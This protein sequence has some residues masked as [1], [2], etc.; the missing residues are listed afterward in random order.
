MQFILTQH[1]FETDASFESSVMLRPVSEELRWKFV[2]AGS[3]DY[4]RY[5]LSL[6]GQV[7]SSI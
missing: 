2:R 7:S 3:V 5:E 4:T 1:Y 6:G